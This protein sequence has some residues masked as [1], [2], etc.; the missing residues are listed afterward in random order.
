[1]KLSQVFATCLLSAPLAIV[2]Q[3]PQA[4]A[5]A[6]SITPPATVTVRLETELGP[7]VLAIETVRAPITAANFLR[8]VNDK[9]LDGSDFYRAMKIGDTGEYGLLQGGL[10]GN[11]R[12]VFKP[13]AHE[14]THITGLSHV[15]G[16]VSMART[17]PG[18]ATADFFIVWGD[19]PSLDSKPGSDAADPATDAGYAVFG[20]VVEGMELVRRMLEL[21]RSEVARTEAMKGQM[22]EKPV[23]ILT[24]RVVASATAPPT[25][26]KAY[27]Q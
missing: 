5:A 14:P 17:A 23:K 7:I 10:R 20:R 18:T 15:S 9:R 4:T 13:I 24:A 25:P 12:R 6:S 16:A 8:Y 1:M 22:L 3:S 11:P 26:A 27:A 2:A 21:P 19:L